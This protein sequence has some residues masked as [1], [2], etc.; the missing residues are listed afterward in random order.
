MNGYLSN[1]NRQYS[2][3]YEIM[4]FE[5]GENRAL[6]LAYALRIIEHAAGRHL[7]NF[8]LSYD[9]LVRHDAVFLLSGIQLEFLR[10]INAGEEVTIC[11]WQRKIE[12]VRYIRDA[13]ILGKNGEKLAACVQNWF[14][15]SVGQHRIKRPNELPEYNVILPFDKASLPDVSVIQIHMPEKTEYAALHEVTYSDLDYNGHMN[16]TRYAELATDCAS[17]LLKKGN[18]V[19]GIKLI[20]KSEAMLSDTLKLY[21]AEKDGRLYVL[22]EH[23]RGCCFEAELCFFD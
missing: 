17:K 13:E 8:N 12:K 18:R 20:F 14:I 16:N 21:A 15:A 7:D 22:G 6:T 11:T 3:H 4:P 5:C 2:E 9:E 1:E 19:K 10:P 23:E